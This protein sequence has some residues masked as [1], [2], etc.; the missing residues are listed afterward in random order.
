LAVEALVG[1]E[2]LPA[3]TTVVLGGL[4]AQWDRLA[5][6]EAALGAEDT[7]EGKQL[8]LKASY[9][10]MRLQYQKRG[11]WERLN[12]LGEQLDLD[13]RDIERI[14]LRE[15]CEDRAGKS[16][17]RIESAYA[18]ATADANAS[19]WKVELDGLQLDDGPALK[20]AWHRVRL[21]AWSG[22]LADFIGE[23]VSRAGPGRTA[24]FISAMVDWGDLNIFDVSS[25]LKSVPKALQGLAAVRAA[26]KAAVLDVCKREPHRVSRRGR[27]AIL[28]LARLNEDGVVSDE[29]VVDAMLRGY[30]DYVE[31]ADASDLFH[32]LDA[33]ATKLTA[34]EAAETLSY[35]LTLLQEALVDE[36]GDGAWSDQLRPPVETLSSLAGYIWTGLG[37]PKTAERWQFAHVVRSA[38]ALCRDNLLNDLAVL[39]RNAVA[40]PYCDQRLMFYSWHAR[41][42]LLIG[43]AR[44]TCE[45]GELP[46]SCIALLREELDAPH[47]LIRGFAAQAL[48]DAGAVLDTSDRA[49]L[50]DINV[51]MHAET[52]TD[53]YGRD[54]QPECSGMDKADGKEFHFGIDIGRYWFAPLGR[55]FKLTEQAIEQRAR[56][57]IAGTMGLHEITHKE[58]ARYACGV[59]PKHS[60]D[61]HHS[62]GDT[63]KV[64]D[65]RAYAAY[66]SM[67][68]V[69]A[70]LLE[71]RP[72][73]RGSDEEQNRFAEWLREQGLTRKSG[74]WLADLRDPQ[75]TH[76]PSLQQT[77]PGSDWYW[78]A[79]TDYLDAQLFSDDG[80]HVVWGEWGF[81]N[82]GDA[83]SISVASALTTK[84]LAPALLAALQTA[85]SDRHYLPAT[86]DHEA[87]STS[88][89][90][91]HPWVDRCHGCAR[92]DERDPWAGGLRYPNLAPSADVV[93]RLGL[94]IS[95]DGRIW[96]GRSGGTLRSESWTRLVGYGRE[97]TSNPGDR[98]VGDKAFIRELISD[99]DDQ[100]LILS[101]SV[102]VHVERRG[103]EDEDFAKYPWPYRR[104]YLIDQDGI[105]RT[106]QSRHHAR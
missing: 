49:R 75:L 101:V 15:E 9:R 16:S 2:R 62:H 82:D 12:E 85:M 7:K 22:T 64:D 3:K 21:H 30:V 93:Q 97:Q 106:L 31:Q 86:S 13:L 17:T 73:A 98:L 52:M 100:C 63:P 33:L 72:T 103:L 102:R 89:L 99:T 24:A 105:T 42:W 11:T 26:I 38:V 8:V 6:L 80:R 45:R 43:L 67:M 18:T 29:A 61:T 76:V 50:R 39:A 36:K 95:E 84:A 23:G 51:S 48:R 1:L 58:D 77:S 79:T 20:Q 94:T 66:H 46:D 74:M 19:A 59:F 53:S 83:E 47:V 54:L 68:L 60:W 37:S 32:I 71:K 55:A 28:P 27:W 56:N 5:S 70:D 40:G 88:D 34:H 10:Y 35:G 57:V 41:Q 104:Y 69:A 14:A 78:S 92:L 65:L 87:E 25:I 44:G 81:G 90:P 91:L 96:T 4:D